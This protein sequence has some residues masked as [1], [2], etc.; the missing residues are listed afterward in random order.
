MP[1]WDAPYDIQSN[2]AFVGF[3][4]D[5]SFVGGGFTLTWNSHRTTAI[6][7]TNVFEAHEYITNQAKFLF[8]SVMFDSDKGELGKMPNI[9]VTLV[10]LVNLAI[11]TIFDG[12]FGSFVTI[13]TVFN[14][15][16]YDK[17]F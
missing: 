14:R 16:S 8:A 15:A 9:S 12:H 11:A 2:T 1:F 5:Q 6:D 10:I 7:F 3:D 13:F 17:I 4:A